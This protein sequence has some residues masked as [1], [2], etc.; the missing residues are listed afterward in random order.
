MEFIFKIAPPILK[1]LDNYLRVNHTWIWSTKV[2]IHTY[3][4]LLLGSFFSMVAA[5]Y[6]VDIHD[7]VSVSEQDTFFGLLFIPAVIFAMYILYNMSL[8]NTD[9]S[10][11]Y[12]FKYQE[13]FLYILFFFNLALPLLIP[14]PAAF[15]LNERVDNLVEDS[16]FEQDKTDINYGIG[17]FPYKAYDFVYYPTDSIYIIE[18]DT[19][20][21]N[22]FDMH[23]NKESNYY[24]A[25]QYRDQ[26]LKEWG[27]FRDS[28]YWHKG[29]F[30][31][32]RPK[33]YYQ[34]RNR[35]KKGY[36]D[37]S[38]Y[39]Y[40]YSYNSELYK[41]SLL[42]I[43]I[44]ALNTK[45]DYQLAA[46]YIGK[47]SK[48]IRKYYKDT[49][50]DETVI[51]NDFKIHNYGYGYVDENIAHSMRAIIINV[52]RIHGAKLRKVVV[53]QS[54]FWVFLGIF[55][56]C[57]TLLYSIFKSVHWK[58]FLLSFGT[59]ALLLTVILIIEVS[60]R[61]KG[62]FVAL[63]GVILPIVL[64]F[65]TIQGFQIKKFSWILSQTNILL[66]IILPFYPLIVLFYLDEYHDIFEIAYFD[67]FKEYY[68]DTA[69]DEQWNYNQAYYTLV[70][71]IWWTT[72]YSGLGIYVVAWN[73]YLKT[74]YLR[75]WF[76]PKKT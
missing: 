14:L 44:T 71:F 52:S 49:I 56:F 26:K 39:A 42:G 21:S 60:F 61:F 63:T 28:I 30:K 35:W 8:F 16:Q 66:S 22:N 76:L 58:Q 20:E 65:K 32:T 25:G 38:E 70:S 7:V 27:E 17:Y 13:F 1:D 46:S 23:Y 57:L 37:Y 36:Y 41:D 19:I 40:E 48:M 51:L 67:Q 45:R 74:L 62:D 4:A 11:S 75:Y 9:K 55:V 59:S 53:W 10:C 24:Y 68:I 43:H 6:I 47:V 72:F 73:S 29:I 64:L 34:Y 12:R 50:V 54:G 18:T 3:M 31:N 33:L 5:I 15:I 69:G 2:H